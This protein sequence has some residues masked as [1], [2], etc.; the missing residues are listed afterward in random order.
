MDR[1]D[2]LLMTPLQFALFSKNQ[3]IIKLLTQYTQRAERKARIRKQ[4]EQ[5]NAKDALHYEQRV[6]QVVECPMIVIDRGTD[7]A[8]NKAGVVETQLNKIGQSWCVI[9]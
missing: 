6:S 7:Q 2:A 4:Y 8:A 5:Y 1:T 3:D 9:L